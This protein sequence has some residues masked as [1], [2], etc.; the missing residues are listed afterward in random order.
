M[1]ITKAAA[2]VAAAA[3]ASQQHDIT[4]LPVGAEHVTSIALVQSEAFYCLTS[5]MM[6]C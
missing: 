3:V 6:T 2:A 4:I 5:V 1:S